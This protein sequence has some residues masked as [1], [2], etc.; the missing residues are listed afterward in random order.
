MPTRPAAA[1][2]GTVLLA[3]LAS[4]CTGTATP[5][6][7]ASPAPPPATAHVTGQSTPD[8]SGV[9]ELRDG[10]PV[11]TG[12]S[13]GYYEGMALDRADPQVVSGAGAITLDD[14]ADGDEVEVWLAGGACAESSPVQCDV[15]TVRV[16]G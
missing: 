4:G 14:L 8:V 15:G 11:L 10:V 2:L 6:P 16:R 13:D 5:T 1:V 7:G 3:A 9:V 12:A